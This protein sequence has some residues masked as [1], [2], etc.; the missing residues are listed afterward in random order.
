MQYQNQPLPIGELGNRM[1]DSELALYLLDWEDR[2]RRRRRAVRLTPESGRLDCRP[3][4]TIP[5]Q[6]GND[7]IQPR[8]ERGSGSIIGRRLKDAE[9]CILAD[10]FSQ[11]PVMQKPIGQRQHLRLMSANKHLQRIMPPF[12]QQAHQLLIIAI[13]QIPRC[14]RVA[15]R[16][17]YSRCACSTRRRPHAPIARPNQ[18]PSGNEVHPLFQRTHALNAVPPAPSAVHANTCE[19][20][21]ADV[22]RSQSVSV[23]ALIYARSSVL[24]PKRDRSS[25]IQ[26]RSHRAPRAPRAAYSSGS[27]RASGLRFR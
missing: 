26:S 16:S 19:R 17:E 8:C 24:N 13:L 23:S 20:P 27:G 7:A 6:V 15:H 18:N 12:G 14:F 22:L 1:P 3:P 2:S 4:T 21:S 11:L 10:I 9:E 5:T 25:C